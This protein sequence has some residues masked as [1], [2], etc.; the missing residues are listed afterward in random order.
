MKAG[1]ARVAGA[2]RRK[3]AEMEMRR[4]ACFEAAT[5]LLV[6]KGPTGTS[7]QDIAD[8]V[9]ISVGTLYNMFGSKDDLL[10]A[11]FLDMHNEEKQRMK[12]LMETSVGGVR[13]LLENVVEDMIVRCRKHQLLF[14]MIMRTQSLPDLA[15]KRTFKDLMLHREKMLGFME[16]VMVRGIREGLIRE[17]LDPGLLAAAI[18]GSMIGLL[19]RAVEGEE[20]IPAGLSAKKIVDLLLSGVGRREQNA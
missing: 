17:D 14:R 5:R 3:E 10:H 7:M 18:A 15:T 6:E 13:G 9:G 4:K 19:T 12:D 16:E 2:K 11:L 8:A 1:S 20:G